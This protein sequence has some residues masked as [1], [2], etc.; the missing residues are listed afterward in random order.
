M[1]HD[2]ADVRIL[3]EHLA[4]ARRQSL[5]WLILSLLLFGGI[6]AFGDILNLSPDLRLSGLIMIGTLIIVNAVWQASALAI[7]RI[8]RLVLP[9]SAMH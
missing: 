1:R 6:Y 8:E 7:A 3:A 2:S 5:F 4:W 9:R